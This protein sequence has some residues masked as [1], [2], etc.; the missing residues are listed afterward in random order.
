MS[1]CFPRTLISIAIL[2]LVLAWAGASGSLHAQARWSEASTWPSGR[3]PAAGE[4]VTI[5]AGAAVVLDVSPPPLRSLT[6]AGD[7]RF[8]DGTDLRLR[9]GWIYVTGELRIGSEAEPHRARATITIDGPDEDVMGMGGRF[10]ATGEGGSLQL[11]GASALKRS[12]TQLAASVDAGATAIDLA[13]ATAWA[14]GDELAIAPSGWDPFEAERVTITAVADER[15]TFEPA[16]QYPHYG[17]VQYYG[18]RAVD[19]RAEVGLLTRNILIEGPETAAA[20]RYGAHGMVMAGSGPIAVEGVAF[21]RMGQPA[22]AARYTFHWHLCGERPGDYIRK[23]SIYDGLQRGIVVHGT[24]SVAVSENVVF[25]VPNHAYIPAEDGNEIGNRFVGNLAILVKQ[26]PVDDFAFPRYDIRDFSSQGEQRASGFWLRNVDNAL[27]GNHVAGA[28]RGVGFFYDSFGRSRA[29]AAFDKRGVSIVFEDNLAHTISVPGGALKEGTANV[30]MYDLIG[31]GHGLF[32]DRFGGGDESGYDFYDFTAYKCAMAAIWNET[33]AVRFHDFVMADNTS[34]LQTGA[35]HVRGATVV[36]QTANTIGGPNRVLR[37][38]HRRAGYYTISQGGA[39]TPRLSDVAFYNMD[40]NLAEGGTRTAAIILDDEMT[41]EAGFVEGISVDAATMPIYMDDVVS[42]F[43]SPRATALWD[44][45]G[46][47]SQ[48]EGGRVV[49]ERISPL[50]RGDCEAIEA[51]NA[52]LCPDDAFLDAV[53]TSDDQD[54]RIPFHL[55]GPTGLTA[56]QGGFH[57]RLNRIRSGEAYTVKHDGTTPRVGFTLELRPFAANEGGEAY[58]SYPWP[59]PGAHLTEESGADVP[60][61][62]DAAAVRQAPGP[63]YAFDASA[64]QLFVKAIAPAEGRRTIHFAD[65]DQVVS[66][67]ASITSELPRARLSANPFSPTT[68]LLFTMPTVGPV[69]IALSDAAGR[70]LKEIHVGDLRAGDHAVRLTPGPLAPGIY[71]VTLT[72]GGRT[73]SL[74]LLVAE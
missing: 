32:F 65:G 43:L 52:F 73:E 29:H 5:P 33:K 62:A 63:A 15:I 70:R 48:R 1:I 68:A 56:R 28:E 10:L 39:K 18:G 9:A 30:A 8:A 24:D 25:N 13:D 60:R 45:D 41:D 36:G 51:W 35:G 67:G 57:P 7:L 66:D 14:V 72:R 58:F 22:R 27:I 12:W 20:E 31:H 19:E 11:H 49:V 46:S 55:E 40:V 74:R 21:R 26:V 54:Q 59:F 2:P 17:E 71:V 53:L 61:Y 64:G 4:A 16:L 47:L 38:G 34:A 37:H 3:V 23:T 42:E 44:R 6:V 69:R 50:V